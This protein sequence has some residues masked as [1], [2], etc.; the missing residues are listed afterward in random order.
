MVHILIYGI[1]LLL[2]V[3]LT[4][5]TYQFRQLQKNT[6]TIATNE[7][8]ATHLAWGQ[9]YVYAALVLV[10]VL[11]IAYTWYVVQGTPWQGHLMEWLN[12][13][14]RL[15]HI[16]FGIAWIGASFYFVFLENALNRTEDVR[17]E[18]A[19]NLWAV[20]GGGFYY[21]EKYKVAPKAV[22]KH[23]HWFKYEA[24]FTWVSGFALLFVVYYFNAKAMLIDANVFNM[25]S[26]AAIAIGVGSFA[27]AW[28]LYDLLCKSSLIKKPLLFAVVGFVLLTTF[29]YLYA[30]VFSARAA[31]I[32]F[33]AMI[34]SLMAANVFFVIIPAQKAMVAA[35]K[36][37]QPVNPVLG[38]NALARSLHNNYFTLPVLFVMIS[39]H[40]P[41]TFGHTHSWAVLAAITLGTAGVKHYLNLKE[42]GQYNVCI[43]PL[44]VL[45]LLAV[46]FVTAPPK[47]TTA[48]ATQ[49]SFAQINTIIQQRCI[50]CH[51]SRPTDDVYT[52]P[53]NGVVYDTPNDIVQKKDLIMQRVVV[54]KTMPQNNKT[55]ITPQERELIRC[56]IEQGANTQ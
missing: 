12:I 26:A 6:G 40:F 47:T 23:L 7:P 14:V 9:G 53:P 29:A 27:V 20:H 16:T 25:G 31:Y 33:G 54:T 38:K 21:L 36:I 32:H 56:W 51:S 22:P 44:A 46:A 41:S 49:V 17:D 48:C 24:Y 34:G 35:A 18:L 43:L 13:V 19:G 2:L 3:S 37:G 42:K 5:I 45:L 4:V 30:Q 39:N 1:L 11:L 52:A 55:N 28:I 8:H 50:S 10:I 15:M